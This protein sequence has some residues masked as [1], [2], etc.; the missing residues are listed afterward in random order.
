NLPPHGQGGGFDPANP[1]T[2][3]GYN[4][5]PLVP[6]G[7]AFGAA[8]PPSQGGYSLPPLG[9]QGAG[10]N[11]AY[12]PGQGGYNL[13][14]IGQQGGG[15]NPATPPGQGGYSLPPL[16]QQGA[17]FNPAYPSGQGG[18]N[19]PPIGQQGGGFGAAN[20]A[21]PAYGGTKEGFFDKVKNW[22][23][24][25][26]PVYPEG[27]SYEDLRELRAVSVRKTKKP[28]KKDY[29][30][31]DIFT[32]IDNG[33]SGGFNVCAFLLGYLWLA[34]SF[35]LKRALILALFAGVLSTILVL[36]LRQNFQYATGIFWLVIPILIGL[37]AN[38]WL[39]SS[40][41]QEINKVW[42]ES[43]HNF[44]QCKVSVAKNRR[45]RWNYFWLVSLVAC[46]FGAINYY[47]MFNS[48]ICNN[49]DYIE[50]VKDILY[51]DIANK[52]SRD[53]D[54]FK[55]NMNIEIIGIEKDKYNFKS[56]KCSAKMVLT[57]VREGGT[58][59]TGIN[60]DVDTSYGKTWEYYVMV[61]YGQLR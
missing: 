49:Q 20:P 3:G 2:Q 50:T 25:R 30:Y 12:P 38:K 29:K 36:I 55:Q 46:L 52:R 11:P 45:K 28:H 23:F 4:L 59:S 1:P 32:G 56:C 22:F 61:R 15:F 51:K 24:P 9:Q 35:M 7:A 33:K 21:M 27:M 34:Y 58:T 18:Y 43:G 57:N 39:Y 53:V 16:G 5:P 42:Q 17:G 40:V 13:P 44:E 19:L 31:A 47:L 6:Q 8:N 54:T 10:F 60:Y 14:P 41:N 26:N 48:P 37:I